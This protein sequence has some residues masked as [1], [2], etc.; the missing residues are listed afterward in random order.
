MI[1]SRLLRHKHLQRARRPRRRILDPATGTGTFIVGLLEHF[2]GNREK[3]A[4]KYKEELHANEVAILPYYVANLNIEA[5]YHAITGQFA[6]FPGRCSSTRS[7]MSTRS[8]SIQATSTICSA[9]SPTRMPSASSARTAARSASSS[10]TRRTTPTSRTKTRTT[11]T[12]AYARV[13]RAHQAD[14][15]QRQHRTENQALRHVRALLSLG[16]RPARVT[17]AL[18]RSSRT[19]ASLR[20]ERS[21]A[22]ANASP[23]DFSDIWI[24]DLGDGCAR[25]SETLRHETQRIRHPSRSGNRILRSETVTNYSS[26]SLPPTAGKRRSGRQA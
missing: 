8:E 1:R 22:F 3:L 10:A 24:V 26:N 13:D 20:A 25:Q 2:R 17:K 4:Y 6:E 11:R 9:P 23:Q 18:S 16:E 7:T 15:H 14:L 5:T 21:T 12:G 19:G